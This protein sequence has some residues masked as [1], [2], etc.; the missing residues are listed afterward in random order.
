VL[1]VEC[2]EFTHFSNKTNERLKGY[3]LLEQF[4]YSISGEN[5]ET[6]INFYI[7]SRL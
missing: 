1:F 3:R 4:H 5:S 6:S 2:F 7:L